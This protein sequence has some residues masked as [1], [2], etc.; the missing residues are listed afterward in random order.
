METKSK[1]TQYP[2]ASDISLQERLKLVTKLHGFG[3]SPSR[4]ATE[5]GYDV[6]HAR[7]DVAAILDRAREFDD[8]DSY[9]K[10]TT[11]R[12]GEQLTSLNAQKAIL[13]K[14]LDWAS[15]WIPE[16]HVFPDGSSVQ[17]H[18][19][20]G[21]PLFGPRKPAMVSQLVSQIQ[22]LDKQIGE[23]LG[24]YTKNV[25]ISV[26]LQKTEQIQVI[27]FE[28]IKEQEPEVYANLVRRVTAAVEAAKTDKNALLSIN[29]ARS[30]DEL[31]EGEVVENSY[32]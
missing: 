14:Q 3:F 23:I 11:T 2:K 29:G 28:I 9:I 1:K 21:E 12:L 20:D 24:L 16:M 27:M 7:L 31:I 10:D 6:R 32:A 19:E 30:V 18:G 22:S 15:D 25:D 17:K 8:L 5:L 4:I 26:T 13:W